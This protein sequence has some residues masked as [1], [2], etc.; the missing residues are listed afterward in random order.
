MNKNSKRIILIFIVLV[1]FFA[2]AWY[3]MD[4]FI[5]M[6]IAVILSILGSPLVKLLMRIKIKKFSLPKSAAAALTLVVIVV[7]L[8]FLFYLLFPLV[9]F[10]VQ[11]LSKID[12]QLFIGSVQDGLMQFEN[13][14]HQNGFVS[15][16]FHLSELIMSQLS[17]IVS[18][19]N[20]SSLFGNVLDIFSGAFICVFSVIFMTYF[21]LKDNHI[22]WKMIKKMIPL[23]LRGNFD[24]ILE[25]TKSQLIRYFGGVLSEMALVGTLEGVFC[26]ILGVPNAMLIGFIGGLLNII[27]YVGPLMAGGIAALIGVTST[28]G[29]DPSEA[30]ISLVLF[31][32]VGAFV[33]VKLL[34][35]FIF[36]PVIC[37]KSVN[38]H[39]LEIFV[40]IL[41]SGR[42]GGILGMIFAVPAY[43]L[44]RIIVK[45]FFSQ[46][47]IAN[48][49]FREKQ[50]PMIEHSDKKD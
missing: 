2:A 36:Q 22:F 41:V 13:Y 42:I 1:A 35:D 50:L 5:Y 6:F 37:G 44:V 20:I 15:K 8:S 47:F 46:Y 48:E 19:I 4:I 27:P 14:L 40:V 23:S 38:A 33:L 49:V 45:E 31:K 11:Q 17:G 24:N 16:D 10:E 28:L 25:E 43:T 18:S 12:P 29:I 26:Y 34:D 3:F 7:I 21:A 30:A 39:P 9:A 32:V